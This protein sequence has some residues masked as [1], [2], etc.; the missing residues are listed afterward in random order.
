[1]TTRNQGL[2]RRTFLRST[3]AG[4]AIAGL[5]A[6]ERELRVQGLVRVPE[7][8]SRRDWPERAARAGLNTI[9]LHHPSS[10]RAL[11]E[12]VREDAGQDFL[13]RCRNNKIQIEF[14]FHAMRDL[15]PRDRFAAD[16]SLFRMNEDGQRTPDRNFCAHSKAAMTIAAENALAFARAFPT[17][18]G[19]Y[20]Y[21]SDGCASWC[22]CPDCRGFSDSEQPLLVANAIARALRAEIPGALVAHLACH[23]SMP[24]PRQ[25]KPE[26]GVFLQFAPPRRRYDIPY[27]EQTR[28]EQVD[29]LWF[30]DRNLE[31]FPAETAQALEYWL[32]VS[33]F[34]RGRKEPLPWNGDR[35]RADLAAYRTRGIRQ[36]KSFVNDLDAEYVRRNGAPTFLPEFAAAL[37][38]AAGS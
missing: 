24:A 34:S 33:L 10:P 14:D 12:F 25:V 3:A 36:F 9:A 15:V 2:G 19:R 20:Y 4:L 21:W 13:A 37:R 32:D 8:L 38:E 30:L 28:P 35:V 22:R 7:T 16:P 1:M 6:A 11:L 17:T 27:S 23:A 31:V 26:P 5:G 18:T 29:S